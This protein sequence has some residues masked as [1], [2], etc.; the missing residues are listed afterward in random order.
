MDSTGASSAR[1]TPPPYDGAEPRPDTLAVSLFGHLAART[2]STV[3]RRKGRLHMSVASVDQSVLDLF[4]AI[5]DEH[6]SLPQELV[7]NLGGFVFK[8]EQ[9]LAASLL[10]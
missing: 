7:G 9:T 10:G 6:D 8:R 4:R 5:D 1:D 3:G 2:G